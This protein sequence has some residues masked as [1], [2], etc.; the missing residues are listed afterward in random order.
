MKLTVHIGDKV[1]RFE[2]A[3]TRKLVVSVNG[4]SKKTLRGNINHAIKLASAAAKEKSNDQALCLREYME[5]SLS[6]DGAKETKTYGCL[7]SPTPAAKKLTELS[8]LM[9]FM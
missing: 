5:L 7:G 8:N 1:S 3:D 2:I 4:R 6:V 9:L